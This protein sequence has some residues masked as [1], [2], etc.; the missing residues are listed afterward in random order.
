MWMNKNYATHDDVLSGHKPVERSEASLLAARTHLVL[1][2]LAKI[3]GGIRIRLLMV[4]FC[5]GTHR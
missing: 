3:C 1:F 4:M 2:V 5:Q